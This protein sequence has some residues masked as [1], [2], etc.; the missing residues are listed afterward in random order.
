[1]QPS[2][3]PPLKRFV[4][5]PPDPAG[6][7]RLDSASEGP[8]GRRT[9]EPEVYRLFGFDG[10][11]RLL[12]MPTSYVERDR[13]VVEILDAVGETNPHTRMM[14]AIRLYALPMKV[15]RRLHEIALHRTP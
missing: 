15:L 6:R 10:H 3:S 11:E 1:M 4:L 9:N 5:R 14:A 8:D 12:V 13:L 2:P 7:P